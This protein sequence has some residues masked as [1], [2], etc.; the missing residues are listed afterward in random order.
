[1]GEAS[2]GDL[3]EWATVLPFDTRGQTHIAAAK[4]LQLGAFGRSISKF[5]THFK[6]YDEALEDFSGPFAF[7]NEARS[8]ARRIK[9]AFIIDGTKHLKELVAAWR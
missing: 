1:M 2:E 8:I 6:N 3:C 9:A 5:E 7:R 4:S